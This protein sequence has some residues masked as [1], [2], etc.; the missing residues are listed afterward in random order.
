M[1]PQEDLS[2][3]TTP[4]PHILVSQ[5]QILISLRLDPEILRSSL[6]LN[7][8]TSQENSI[9]AQGY[10]YWLMRNSHFRT[11]LLSGRLQFLMIKSCD[12]NRLTPLSFF[13]ALLLESLQAMPPAISAHICC[14]VENTDAVPGSLYL[15]RCLIA[16]IL[17]SGRPMD[18]SFIGPQEYQGITIHSVPHLW[19][20]FQN[21]VSS[22]HGA[23][24]FCIID[25][26][27]RYP[28]E[29]EALTLVH[30]LMAFTRQLKG[31]VYLKV[32]LTSPL[33]SEATDIVSEEEMLYMPFEP[34][35]DREI[36]DSRQMAFTYGQGEDF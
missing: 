26:A 1:V 34:A 17:Y 19:M 8:S 14:G 13:C 29:Q 18:L 36:M 24:I 20:L 3:A 4:E 16:Q 15:L 10:A 6:R 33:P 21:L 31:T 11:W 5:H 7:Y 32:L 2:R 30:A 28:D 23:T 35:M 22:L 12:V 25:G 27:M 9:R